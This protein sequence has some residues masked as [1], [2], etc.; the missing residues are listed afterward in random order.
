MKASVRPFRLNSSKFMNSP[1]FTWK[2]DSGVPLVQPGQSW[3][4]APA[5]MGTAAPPER[6]WRAGPLPREGKLRTVSLQVGPDP[7]VL[8]P[9]LPAVQ[10]GPLLPALS[11]PG[12]G[13]THL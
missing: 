10:E 13:L 4:E 6:G 3:G 2:L 12:P 5:Q 11:L 7:R 1:R 9:L 8:E